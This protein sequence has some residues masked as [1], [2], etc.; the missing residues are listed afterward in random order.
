MLLLSV[1][2]LTACTPAASTEAEMESNQASDDMEESE[3]MEVA[4]DEEMESAGVVLAEYSDAAYDA[5][6]AD[7]KDVFL[8]FYASWCP[9]CVANTPELEAAL[10]A[11]MNENLV[12]FKVDYDNSAD[13]QEQFEVLSQSTYILI[14]GG[15]EA[16]FDVLGPG[17]FRE[18]DFSGLLQ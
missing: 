17:L 16:D 2:A 9:T 3:T 8:E 13:L 15:D 11:S 14:S 5:A 7:G 12:A 4:E 10:D 18:D 1:M 6:I